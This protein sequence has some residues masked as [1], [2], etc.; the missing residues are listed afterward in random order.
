MAGSPVGLWDRFSTSEFWSRIEKYD[1]T[2]ATLLS[3]MWTWLEKEPQK[4]GDRQNTL[5]KVH[6][7]P[8]PTE[9]EDIATR[10]GFD[11]IS[12]IFGQTEAGSPVFGLINPTDEETGTPADL[13]QGKSRDDIVEDM[14]RIDVDVLDEAPGEGYAGTAREFV[15]VAILDDDDERLP[16]NEV[17]EIC[18][19]FDEAGMLLREYYNKPE[20]TVEAWQN[21]WHHT[22]DA[23]YID[24][25]GN[26]FYVDRI[27]D[28]VRRRGENISSIQ[29]QEI[30]NS[31]EKSSVAAAFPV[32]AEEGGEDEIAVALEIKDGETLSEESLRDYLKS[33]MPEFMI[34]RYIE[35][36]DFLPTTETN[37][38]EKYKLK[39][40][41]IEKYSL[42]E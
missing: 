34:P 13:Y 5:S 9:Y 25:D 6:I 33:Q 41:V 40:R 16:P 21:L 7:V 39:Q 32:P 27:G 36:V 37:K 20:R 14:K 28:V 24:E 22:G 23:C 15:D 3:V 1:A 26:V 10:F 11:F 8:L 29:V 2:V 19:R 18:V 12:V 42:D 4:P 38:I 30:I 17:G 31:Y 35:V